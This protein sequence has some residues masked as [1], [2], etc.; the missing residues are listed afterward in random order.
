MDV[1]EAALEV[2]RR[3]AAR[4]GLAE[5]IQFHAGD[6]F[7]ALAG[8]LKFDLILSNPPYI[9]SAEIPTLQPEVRDYDPLLAL[10]GGADGLANEQNNN[11]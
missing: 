10:D 11:K 4:H 5:R 6:G 1:S 8:G 2:A 3:N 7:A 9:P